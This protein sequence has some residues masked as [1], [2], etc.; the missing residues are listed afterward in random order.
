MLTLHLF[1]DSLKENLRADK[2][3]PYKREPN[4]IR[5]ETGFHFSE[6]ISNKYQLQQHT[7][8]WKENYD[9]TLNYL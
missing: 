2:T 9:T 1:T 5:H 8:R 3:I 7:I 6:V 4:K